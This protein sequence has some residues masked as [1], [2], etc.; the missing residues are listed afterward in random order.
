MLAWSCNNSRQTVKAFANLV[1]LDVVFFYSRLLLVTLIHATLRVF[2]IV[3]HIRKKISN[4]FFCLSV[5]YAGC[6]LP[7]LLVDIPDSLG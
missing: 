2:F 4:R 6:V 3:Y 1:R 7:F 5:R